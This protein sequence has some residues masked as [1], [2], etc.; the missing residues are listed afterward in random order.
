MPEYSDRMPRTVLV[1]TT[2]AC[3]LRV[4]GKLKRKNGASEVSHRPTTAEVDNE[5]IAA[6]LL[7]YG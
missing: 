1:V 2:A 4:S 6:V 3:S 7:G 5:L